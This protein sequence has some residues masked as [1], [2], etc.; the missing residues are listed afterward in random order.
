MVGF[1]LLGARKNRPIKPEEKN[2]N[3]NSN[4]YLSLKLYDYAIN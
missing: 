2:H 4:L 3:F 1:I